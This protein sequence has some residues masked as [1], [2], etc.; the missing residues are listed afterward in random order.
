VL[1]DAATLEDARGGARELRGVTARALE[2]VRQLA[3]G[4]RPIALDE[5]GLAAALEQYAAEYARAQGIRVEVQVRGVEAGRLPAAVET[6]LY[7]IVQ[8]ALTN[9]AKHAAAQTVSIVVR[10]HGPAVLAI[11]A[12][13]GC[14]FDVK[15]TLGTSGSRAGLGLHGMQERAASLGGSVTIEST[16]GEG[17]TVYARIPLAHPGAASD[18][19]RDVPPPEGALPRGRPVVL[20]EEERDGKDPGSRRR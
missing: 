6:A 13:D 3:R 15:A 16:P 18:D 14:G 17:T 10:R 2:E 12:D 5:L 19:S 8:E 11:V 9:A 7:R 4:L 20:V 1:E